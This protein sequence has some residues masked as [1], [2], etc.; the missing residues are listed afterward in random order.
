MNFL[1]SPMRIVS[2]IVYIVSISVIVTKLGRIVQKKKE[3]NY[4]LFST[5]QSKYNVS[6]L[7]G[8]LIFESLNF[9]RQFYNFALEDY[10]IE[11][12]N[13]GV[14]LSSH[15]YREIYDNQNEHWV[16]SVI[17][18]FIFWIVANLTI[19]MDIYRYQ[20]IEMV[21]KNSKSKFL[22]FSI[23]LV[24]VILSVG[25]YASTVYCGWIVRKF[26]VSDEEVDIH[27]SILHT[28]FFV[29]GFWV[30]VLDFLFCLKMVCTVI[31]FKRSSEYSDRR[32]FLKLTITLTISL[33]CNITSVLLFIYSY[34]QAFTH[35][36]FSM[37]SFH[38][39]L[40]TSLL[41][42]LS[43]IKRKTKK[44]IVIES[45]TELSTVPSISTNKASF[46]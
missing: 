12:E 40:C 11:L 7:I 23:K 36:A 3:N 44:V 33:L 1:N 28:T 22:L 31:Q 26:G 45:V 19:N 24:T 25:N 6:I 17:A 41:E 5:T 9:I 34:D 46:S 2:T 39:V 30:S 16:N 10:F 29:A 14:Y 35:I 27:D 15:Q 42:L 21:L 37:F 20:K 18:L 43:Q 38:V 13:S 8:T 32:I 4:K